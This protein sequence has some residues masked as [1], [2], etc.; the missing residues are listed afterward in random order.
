MVVTMI[1]VVIP[2]YNSGGTIRT[3]VESA[4]AAGAGDVVVVD[5]GSSDDTAAVAR[6][7]G[8]TVVS[9]ANKGPSRAR[10]AGLARAQ[11]EFVVFLDADD[12]LIPE[13]VAHSV[14]LL[15]DD[16]GASVAGGA[17]VGVWPD[18]AERVIPVKYEDNTAAS[19][20]REGF[21]PWPPGAAVVR[22]DSFARAD[23]TLPLPL[24]T[25]F[26][27]DYELFV[28][29]ALVGRVLRHSIPSTRY[30]V[31]EGKSSR[32]PAAVLECKERIRRYYAA[33]IGVPDVGMSQRALRCQASLQR[34]RRAQA[35]GRDAE[36]VAH[37]AQAAISHPV[38]LSGRAWQFV[39]LRGLRGIGRPARRGGVRL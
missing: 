39:Q 5:D 7:A 26:A 10:A 38:H 1:S 18:G 14:E 3:A 33:W 11:G 21:G 34:A 16:V 25:R 13:G 8:A 4:W 20:V 17:T 27:E 15:R 29:L 28:R 19:M 37:L 23:R 6:A 31:F 2:A 12:E 24:N 9:Q 32:N 22:K 30:H 35:L 36:A